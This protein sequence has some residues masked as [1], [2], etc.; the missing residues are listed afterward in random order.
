M[1]CQ[2]QIFWRGRIIGRVGDFNGNGRE[3]L[4]LYYISG[5][6]RSPRFFEFHEIEFV[7]ILD[8][9]TVNAFIYSVS[10]EEKIISIRIEYS[11]DDVPLAVDNNS[12]RWDNSTHRYKLLNT[13][14]NIITQGV[15]IPVI[16]IANDVEKVKVMVWD[17]I[18]N[19]K[20][21]CMGKTYFIN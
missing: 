10:P 3:E 12:Y 19:M 8:I 21:L 15:N 13:E 2:L 5:M 16:T 11:N 17:S 7:E 1:F 9:G 20:P 18:D 4:Y 14:M 6:N